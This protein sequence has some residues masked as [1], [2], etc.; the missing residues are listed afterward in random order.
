MRRFLS[1]SIRRA[2][3]ALALLVAGVVQASAGEYLCRHI[4]IDD[5]LSQSNVTALARDH[6]GFLWIGTRFGLNRFDF[7]NLINYY[8]VDGDDTS[9]PDNLIENLYVDKDDRLWVACDKG[10]ARYDQT[11]NSFVQ[12]TC[13]GEKV[14]ARSFFDE[15]AGVIIGGGGRLY[16]YDKA[17]DRIALLHTKGGTRFYYTDIHYWKPGYYILA[18]RW[19]GL[20]IYDRAHAVI[21][22][23][24]GCDERRIVASMVDSRGRLWVSAYGEG[25][26][27]YER[28]GARSHTINLGSRGL[29]NNI[30]LD[31]VE[32]D[33]EIWLATDGG[34]VNI[35][36][37][38]LDQFTDNDESGSLGSLGSVSALY[39]D[40]H[41]SV[42]CGTVRDGAATIREVAI[43]TFQNNDGSDLRVSAVSS[44]VADGSG[45]V[46]I[47][48]DGQGVFIHEEGSTRFSHVPSTRSL[49]VVNMAPYDDNTL[50]LS[51]FDRGFFLLDK[52]TGALRDV[53]PALK[54]HY[55][56]NAS[57]AL[58]EHIVKLSNGKLAIFTDH[59]ATFDP[60]TG[61]L[62][63]CPYTPNARIT[64]FYN[65]R[66][67]VLGLGD[68][69]IGEYDS[70]TGEARTV[71]RHKGR[72]SCAAFD[73]DH[74]VYVGTES[75]LG[76]LDMTTG[77]LTMLNSSG[78][79]HVSSL[80]LEGE[81]LW[82]GAGNS[83]YLKAL[84]H[85][86]IVSFGRFDGVS[87]NEYIPM[88]CQMTDR[89]VYM[90][91]VNG[92]LRINR[93][94]ISHFYENPSDPAISLSDIEIDGVSLYRN[95]SDGY[96]PVDQ[97][98]NT[99]R[100]SVIADG[101]NAGNH[102][103]YRFVV[104][105]SQGERVIDTYD[106]FI[107]INLLSPGEDYDIYTASVRPDGMAT[108]PHKLLTLA[109]MAPWY[110]SWWAM[111]L[112]ITLVTG[113][114]IYNEIRRRR[115]NARRISSQV[116]AYR[117]A[118]LEKEVAFLV[119]TNHALRTPLTMIYAPVKMLLEKVRS[120]DEVDLENELENIYRN[121]KR[122]RDVIDMAMELHQVGTMPE[123]TGTEPLDIGKSVAASVEQHRQEI[124]NKHIEVRMDV[125]DDAIVQIA[126]A[127]DRFRIVAD[128]LLESAVRRSSDND[129]LTIRVRRLDDGSVRVEFSDH[130]I[131]LPEEQLARLFSYHYAD[132]DQAA[133]NSIDLAYSRS[134][135]EALG[136]HVGADNNS[137]GG[138]TAWLE[139]P[140]GEL[141]ADTARKSRRN[142][143]VVA[144]SP[145]EPILANV[146]TSEMTVIVVEEDN[147]LCMFV[148][149]QLSGHFRR[150]LHAFNG[151]DA[152][153]MIRQN[154]P[155]IVISSVMLPI[156]S[157][158]ELCLDI[159]SSPETSH[160]PVIL[161]TALKEGPSLENAYA[162]GAD[163]YL[164]KPF[165]M[166]VLMLRLRNLLHNRSVMKQRYSE[167]SHSELHRRQLPNA[168]ETF[169]LK[170]DRI[171][172]DNIEDSNFSVDTIAAEM[173]TS[174]TVLYSKFKSI[175]G[176]TIG[177]YVNDYRLRRAKELLR[178]TTLTVSE[179]SEQLGFSSQRYFSTFFKERTGVS[180]TAFRAAPGEA[181]QS[182]SDQ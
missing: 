12:M 170:I 70:L 118:S 119:N 176:M 130:G 96:L 45:H 90:G 66:G 163:S 112:L 3:L 108:E 79:G 100:L 47:G 53:P 168:D 78:L 49:K 18:T 128:T 44:V 68:D 177:A 80:I 126:A 39:I 23:M 95:I 160:I 92:L 58:A 30:V 81:R 43:R 46:W 69:F 137:D 83:L 117:S 50:I 158:I 25:V 5:G 22:R 2:A 162:A 33:G 99:I 64:P 125:A 135:I 31:I 141:S 102:Q 146:D 77:S 122:M 67:L 114:V 106:N 74:T 103:L 138:V 142:V 129:L 71:Y 1:I 61:Q 40:R 48:D 164:S 24:P 51:T 175:T 123:V 13:D 86:N 93:G 94:E 32:K 75:G 35:Y 174:R 116:E 157:G 37:P 84:Q 156:K 151:K 178:E 181:P 147:D 38:E 149:S 133:V 82:I 171:I 42:Y 55:E 152:L 182:T 54:K 76:A 4:S 153:I 41:G 19:D 7:T 173:H 57:K 89:Y 9:L 124:D 111:A 105:S 107:V 154:Q 143:P 140:Q 98:H 8:H 134:I 63:E 17:G 6:R 172:V 15:G 139:L 21:S 166:N 72:L 131:A 26:S 155:D 165:D 56:G 88:A 180:P 109:V 159:K 144:E 27:C 91:G 121:T 60:A 167:A 20:W 34:G 127:P 14:N 148:S 132:S 11:T 73:G 97:G 65:N 120:G 16:Y 115:A 36:S 169:L 52:S 87:A 59:I 179:I 104:R 150:V 161:L 10:A 29:A 110:Q 136:G 62:E 113:T 85:D 28:D 101:E 145:A